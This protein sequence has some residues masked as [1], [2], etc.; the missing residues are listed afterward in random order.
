M[1][2]GPWQVLGLPSF[3]FD[4][5]ARFPVTSTT[6]TPIQYTLRV[7]L[8]YDAVFSRWVHPTLSGGLGIGLRP[9]AAFRYDHM[10]TRSTPPRRLLGEMGLSLG[11][12]IQDYF[13]LNYR[14]DAVLGRSGAGAVKAPA[15]GLRHGLEFGLGFVHRC[16]LREGAR[17]Q[18][19]ASLGVV[20]IALTHDLLFEP[21]PEQALA[22]TA[23]VDG[24]QMVVGFINGLSYA[25]GGGGDC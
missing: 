14:V 23:W 7:E 18:G 19:M 20:G 21:A 4:H 8:G 3:R 5:G 13:V 25:F 22:L 15:Y 17:P 11:V 24:I 16:S 9:H 6:A 10:P 2:P 1:G 12:V